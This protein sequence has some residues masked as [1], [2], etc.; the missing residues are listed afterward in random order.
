MTD[1]FRTALDFVLRW[2]GGFSDHPLDP[3]GATNYG[4]TQATFDAYRRK[5]GLPTRSVRDITRAE[6]EDIYFEGYWLRAG[7]EQIAPPALALCVFDAAVNSGVGAALKW[8]K[9]TSDWRE[10]QALRLEFLTGLT[11]WPTF[12]RGWARRVADLTR[13]AARSETTDQ[14]LLMVFDHAGREHARLNLGDADLLVR[15]R[16]DRVYVRPDTE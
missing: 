10:Y 6:V 2:E 8:L 9:T 13:V 14:R 15:V 7:C 5:A 4:V 16:G 11:T 12:G 3:G 1:A